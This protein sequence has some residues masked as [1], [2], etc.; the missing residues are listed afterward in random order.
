MTRIFTN[1]AWFAFACVA[2]NLIIGLWMGD[3]RS[4]D[5]SPETLNWAR[6]HRLGGVAAGLVVVLVNSIVITYFVGTS[7][8]VREVSETYHL[9]ARF[10][11]E[12]N[13]LKRKTFPW[14]TMCM[15]AVVGLI[16]LGGAADPGNGQPNTEFWVMPHLFAGYGM[17]AFLALTSVVAWNNIH[18]N[19]QVINSVVAEVA[20]IRRE[21]GLEV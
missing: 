21:R 12:S 7:R 3:L 1:L 6:V 11:L 5:P 13:R 9:D 8:W 10:L 19:Q 2:A 16:A 18:G 20:K 14:C 17:L 15:L 4:G